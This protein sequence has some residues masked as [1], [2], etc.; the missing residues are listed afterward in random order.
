MKFYK[1]Y[2]ENRL[3]CILCQHYCKIKEGQTGICGVNK[4]VGDKIECLVY[5]YSLAMNVD[6][7]EKNCYIIFFRDLRPF[8]LVR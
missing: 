2:K 8:H 3:Q 6:P 5:G 4:N 1:P 7:I